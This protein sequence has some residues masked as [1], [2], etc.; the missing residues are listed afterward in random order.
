MYVVVCCCFVFVVRCFL[1]VDDWFDVA[2]YLMCVVVRGVVRWCLV[3]CV[4]L[5]LRVLFVGCCLMFVVRGLACVCCLLL[6]CVL[7]VVC[8]LVLV[9]CCVLVVGCSLL[10][11]VG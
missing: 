4:S 10:C 9:V 1:N 2:C 8:W 3:Y 7:L 6:R 11:V 5:C